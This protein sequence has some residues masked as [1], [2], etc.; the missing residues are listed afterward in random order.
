MITSARDAH[1]RHVRTRY[2]RRVVAPPP[3][4]LVALPREPFRF[5]T[6]HPPLPHSTHHGRVDWQRPPFTLDRELVF[7][8]ARI[9]IRH[10]QVQE[11]S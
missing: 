1:G 11:A 7:T 4:E 2:R 10:A 8:L 3:F 9:S 5:R 6:L